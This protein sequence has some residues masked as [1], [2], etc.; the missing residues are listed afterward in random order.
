MSPDREDFLETRAYIGIFR[1]SLP[2][3]DNMQFGSFAARK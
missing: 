1:N 2:G 3:M